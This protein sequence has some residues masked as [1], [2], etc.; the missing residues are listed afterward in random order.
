ML[1]VMTQSVVRRRTRKPPEERRAEMLTTAS[2]L[3]SEEGLESLTL[4]RVADELGVYPGLVSHYFQTVDELVV[5]AFR[6][7]VTTESDQL[8]ANVA[9]EA[10]PLDRL[11]RLLELLVSRERDGVSLLWLDAWSAFR[12]RPALAGE[13]TRLMAVD[14]QR[15]GDLIRDGVAAGQF[16]AADPLAAASRIYSVIDGLTVLAAVG[17]EFDH[18]AVRELVFTNA[19][20]ELA[21]PPGALRSS[22]RTTLR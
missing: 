16:T 12:H 2:A 9:G 18:A 1:S 15:L 6:H 17:A 19:E 14:Q 5:A 13:V 20:R 11:R 8:Y 21:L 7:A 3:A 10:A 22:S 4:R